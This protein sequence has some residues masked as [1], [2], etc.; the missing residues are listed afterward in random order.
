VV[1]CR[2]IFD[3][4]PSVPVYDARKKMIDFSADLDRLAEVLPLFPGEV[5]V[6]SFSVVGYTCSSYA[7][8]VSGSDS[9]VSHLSLNL[10]WIIVCGT[11]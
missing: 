6:G 3:S 11:P 10:L 7:G 8:S 1:S 5:P 4:R 2:C 9:K